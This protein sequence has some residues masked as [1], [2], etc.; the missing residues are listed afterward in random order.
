LVLR[1][2]GHLGIGLSGVSFLVALLVSYRKLVHG[3]P[4]AGWTSLIAAQLFIGGVL[5]FGLGVVGEYLIRIIESSEARPTYF[6]R[7]RAG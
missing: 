6:V 4:V 2:V 3:I 5:L 7:R 1:L